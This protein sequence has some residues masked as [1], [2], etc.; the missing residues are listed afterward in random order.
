M[1]ALETVGRS[2]NVVELPERRSSSWLTPEPA[3]S[4][5]TEPPARQNAWLNEY[6][7]LEAHGSTARVARRSCTFGDVDHSRSGPAGRVFDR[8]DVYTRKVVGDTASTN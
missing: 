4:P 5:C 7:P 8:S 2:A 6:P 3:A 1:I